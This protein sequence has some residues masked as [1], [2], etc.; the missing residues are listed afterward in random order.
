[1]VATVFYFLKTKR[2]AIAL[3]GYRAAILFNR[4]LTKEFKTILLIDEW[5]KKS[6]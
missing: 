1:M 3:A 6:S 4:N 5:G 2:C